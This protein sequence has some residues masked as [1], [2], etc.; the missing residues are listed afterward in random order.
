VAELRDV[1]LIDVY[2][3]FEHSGHLFPDGIHPNAE[4]ARLIA[5]LIAATILGHWH[6]DLNGDEMVNFKDFCMLAQY[7]HED[8][9][10]FVNHKL[11]CEDLAR[12]AQYWLV[13]FGLVAH[14]KLDEAEG[15]MAHDSAGDH[16]GFVLSANPL[17]RP[18]AGMVKGA[19]GLDGSDDFVS[20][21][22]VLDPA[23]GPFSVLAWIKGGEPGQVVLSQIGGA[24]WLWA[25]P[26]DGKLMTSL[27][28]PAGRFPPQPL[29]SE[30]VITDGDWHRV[31]FTWD[32]S[33]RI[34]YVDDVEVA[35]DTQSS[36]AGSDGGLY[37]GAGKDREVGSS[38][39]GLIDDVRIYDRAVTP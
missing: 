35:K 19:L 38:F 12:L 25:D 1:G 26:L 13:E 27:S 28:A 17:W 14:W 5:E 7:W 4:G 32:G 15:F 6:P 16:D 33:N 21:P 10:P 31:G 30:T 37:I 18:S 9:S 22:F 2:T 23:D 34:L 11:D 29:T 39:S 20:V 24:N 3:P 8:Q 36:L